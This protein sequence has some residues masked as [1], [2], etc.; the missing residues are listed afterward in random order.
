[1]RANLTVL[2]M[3]ITFGETE[4]QDGVTL[5]YTGLSDALIQKYIEDNSALW[6]NEIDQ[7]P[8]ESVGGT[9]GTHTGPGAIAVAWFSK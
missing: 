9:I 8:V 1:M 2:P 6:K 7:L 5:G 4:Y 3:T